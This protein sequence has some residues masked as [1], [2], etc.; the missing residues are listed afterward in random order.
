MHTHTRA[1]MAAAALE[2]GLLQ[3]HM[4]STGF[5]GSGSRPFDRFRPKS[6]W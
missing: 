2:D 4:Y 6:G 1:G 3:V 5:R